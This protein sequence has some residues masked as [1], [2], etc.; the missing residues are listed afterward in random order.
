MTE[1]GAMW[2]ALSEEDKAPFNAKAAELK[3]ANEANQP[4]SKAEQKK[5][6]KA[7]VRTP[8]VLRLV[9]IVAPFTRNQLQ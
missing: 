2:T 7:E 1:L 9:E 4:P 3:A 6:A 8:R 5:A